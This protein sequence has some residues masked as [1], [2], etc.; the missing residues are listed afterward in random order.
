VRGVVERIESDA[1]GEFFLTLANRYGMSMDGPPQD[2]KDR[3]VHVMR[4]TA[5]SHQ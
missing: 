3:V 1:S 4:P 5:Q 2:A